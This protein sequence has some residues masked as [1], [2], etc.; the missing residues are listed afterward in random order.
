MTKTS[1][2]LRIK[3]MAY[4]IF[5]I[6]PLIKPFFKEMF[7]G[8]S[9]PTAGKTRNRLLPVLGILLVILVVTVGSLITNWVS[10]YDSVQKL[11]LRMD[12]LQQQLT[13]CSRLLGLRNN[14]VGDLTKARTQLEL[15]KTHLE[16]K[17]TSLET[18]GKELLVTYQETSEKLLLQ[19]QELVKL[20]LEVEKHR[21]EP[22]RTAVTKPK[23][24]KKKL[25]K[26]TELLKETE[27]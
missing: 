9:V 18:T 14:E 21:A 5:K 3:I 17:I 15:E 12:I 2:I 10:S 23:P 26:Y 24:K 6:F 1:F 8:G 22:P 4:S 27:S 16:S 19:E 13:E 20:R 25:S 11:E 7:M